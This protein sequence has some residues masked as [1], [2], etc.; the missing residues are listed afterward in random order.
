MQQQLNL[1]LYGRT[2]ASEFNEEFSVR[3][4]V[5]LTPNPVTVELPLVAPSGEG[6]V[7]LRLDPDDKPSTFLLLGIQVKTEGGATI[8]KWD[9][10]PESFSGAAGV[11]FDVESGHALVRARNTDPFVI[12]QLDQPAPNI[13]LEASVASSMLGAHE[14]DLADAIRALQSSLRFALDDIA[15]EQEGLQDVVLLNQAMA[16]SEGAALNDRLS[17]IHS[18][19]AGVEK[20][21]D[22]TRT[23]I[24]GEIRDDWRSVRHEIAEAFDA[25]SRIARERDAKLAADVRAEMMKLTQSLHRLHASREHMIAIRHELGA[26]NDE[27]AVTKVSQ[28]KAELNDARERIGKIENGWVWR[29]MHPFGRPTE[30]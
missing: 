6:F 3:R 2:A 27:E 21:L 5:T 19:A 23:D 30:D 1:Q 15:S 4:S 13:V 14:G 29:L 17:D 28:L 8:F 10:R 7:E 18:R 11:T 20:S 9:C 26:L 16:R 25:A 24:L 22:R 12:L